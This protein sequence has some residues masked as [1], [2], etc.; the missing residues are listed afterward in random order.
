MHHACQPWAQV[1]N[2]ISALITGLT[3]QADHAMGAT[4][5]PH[6]LQQWR[7]YKSYRKPM[8]PL[9]TSASWKAFRSVLPDAATASAGTTPS[10]SPTP[11]PPLTDTCIPPIPAVP[12]PE[13]YR[14]VGAITGQYSLDLQ[15]TFAVVE[16][17]DT[18]FKVTR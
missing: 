13:P 6:Q 4:C 11:K 2:C 17:G 16:V 3:S 8:K 12:R 18:Q 5:Q 1:N 15:P 10:R 9:N 14:K 7:G